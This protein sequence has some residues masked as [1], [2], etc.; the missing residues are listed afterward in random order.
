MCLNLVKLCCFITFSVTAPRYPNL[1]DPCQKHDYVEIININKYT[2][3]RFVC[4]R[5]SI[6]CTNNSGPIQMFILKTYFK[7]CNFI[8]NA[9]KKKTD[10]V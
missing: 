4:S 6:P 5:T 1:R 9:L 2:A 8:N 10:K 7:Q 3:N